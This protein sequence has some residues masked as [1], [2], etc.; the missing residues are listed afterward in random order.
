MPNDLN[1][2]NIIMTVELLKKNNI[3]HI[4]ISP[5][6]TNIPFVKMVQDDDFFKCYS[7]IDHS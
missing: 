3:R 6:G 2:K 4:V 7:V 1:I 5:G